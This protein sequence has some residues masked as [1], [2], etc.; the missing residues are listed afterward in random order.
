MRFGENSTVPEDSHRYTI[1]GNHLK[2][3]DNYKDLGVVVSRDL[4]FHK[5]VDIVVGRTAAISNNLLLTTVCRSKEFM[6]TLW[7]SHIRPL[8]EYGSPLWNVG[9]LG[10]VRRLESVQRR[11]TREIDDMED[12]SYEARLRSLGLY[13]IYGR[14]LRIDMVLVWKSFHPQVDVGLTNV[15]ELAND[16]GTRGHRFKLSTPICHTEVG[17]RTFGSR[18]VRHWNSLPRSAVEADSIETF[19]VRLDRALD[20]LLFNSLDAMG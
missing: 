14:L 1:Y 13:S 11:W 7:V 4:K 5:H 10:D 8:M 2:F 16:V 15:F 3:V 20:R 9:Y 19:K 12:L 6:V 18:V 17:R